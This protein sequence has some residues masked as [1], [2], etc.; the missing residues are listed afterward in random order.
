MEPTKRTKLSA[1]IDFGTSNCAVAYSYASEKDNVIVIDNW[2]DGVD[3]HGKI[4]TAILFDENQQ[5]LAF[6]QNAIDRYK[7]IAYNGQARMH[8][9]FRNFKM[10]LYNKVRYVA[11]TFEH[12]PTSVYTEN[13]FGK[14]S[15]YKQNKMKKKTL[16]AIR[17]QVL[18]SRA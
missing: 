16:G 10:E 4:P 2:L 8:Y 15:R 14:L 9:F 13:S 1:A 3:T 5:F 18:R 6:G 12:R 17:P 11:V 7:E